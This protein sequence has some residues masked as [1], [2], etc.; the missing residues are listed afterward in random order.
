MK[1]EQEL[2]A[3]LERLRQAQHTFL[4]DTIS[5]LRESEN[6]KDLYAFIVDVRPHHHYSLLGISNLQSYAQFVEQGNFSTADLL[7]FNGRKYDIDNFPFRVEGGESLDDLSSELSEASSEYYDVI[8]YPEVFP[9]DSVLAERLAKKLTDQHM[10]IHVEVLKAVLP[11][12]MSLNVTDDFVAFVSASWDLNEEEAIALAR[13]TIDEQHFEKAFQSA[14]F[15]T[16]ESID[17]SNA[18]DILHKLTKH[19]LGTEPGE[20]ILH[21]KL[22]SKLEHAL[23]DFRPGIDDKLVD[24]IEQRIQEASPDPEN[25]NEKHYISLFD[26]DGAF[27]STLSHPFFDNTQGNA[28]VE[29]RLVALLGK[30]CAEPYKKKNNEHTMSCAPWTIAQILHA[31]NETRFPPAHSCP[32]TFYLENYKRFLIR[33]V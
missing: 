25:A 20:P 17:L 23:N 1:T 13:Q 24:L 26:K 12:L 9:G 14:R 8:S 27:L 7:G 4:T 2:D 18:E 21:H 15:I 11:S 32:T 16:D 10:Q 29:D 22:V 3:L 30:L 33:P 19:Y 28:A 5:N 31:L 6:N